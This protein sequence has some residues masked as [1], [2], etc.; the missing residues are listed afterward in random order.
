MILEIIWI[1]MIV[2][3]GVIECVVE[4]DM[5]IGVVSVSNVAGSGTTIER[6]IEDDLVM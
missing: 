1:V 2:V 6:L 3:D 4:I 5:I